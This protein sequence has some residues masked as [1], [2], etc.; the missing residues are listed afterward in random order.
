MPKNKQKICILIPVFEDFECL[1]LLEEKIQHHLSHI[2]DYNILVIDDGS[3]NGLDKKL[4][5]EN[6]NRIKILT[7]SQNVGH[8]RS[9]TIGLC[10]IREHC[11][12]DQILIMDG[13]GEDNPADAVK[14]ILES[15]K[16]SEPTIYFARRD[17][18]SEPI[19]FKLGYLLY[20]VLFRVLTG[21]NIKFGNFSL[22][23]NK[24]LDRITGIQ[25][26]WNHYAAS[27]VFAKIPYI[28]VPSSRSGRINGRPKMNFTSLILHG[29]SAISIFHQTVFL[30]L[31]IVS[32]MSLIM[33]LAILMMIKLS[34]IHVD[35]T[36][37]I[38]SAYIGLFFVL[39]NFTAIIFSLNARNKAPSI[40]RRYWEHFIKKGDQ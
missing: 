40:P 8:Q 7:L 1:P 36:Y 39:F 6:N 14:L 3:F 19:S 2:S 37:L 17:T 24:M 4:G 29:L 12:Y 38:I 35:I 22:V 13:D 11:D 9:I 18:R 16:H 31:L 15:E 32:L 33:T 30:R 34:S 23:P 27:I 28:E 5:I 26:I 25:E 21:K 10:Y 20:R